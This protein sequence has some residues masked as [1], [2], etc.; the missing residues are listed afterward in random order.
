MCIVVLDS[1]MWWGW[2]SWGTVSLEGEH[3]GRYLYIPHRKLLCRTSNFCSTTAK[4]LEIFSQLC[5]SKEKVG[6][7]SFPLTSL[8]KPYISQ[9]ILLS[10][11]VWVESG[12]IKEAAREILYIIDNQK[13]S[14]VHK[15][16][17]LTLVNHPL[18]SFTSNIEAAEYKCYNKLWSVCVWDK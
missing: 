15:F 1:L 17:V 4:N 8:L 11:N 3:S 10:H 12:W 14:K 9:V 18:W 13:P 2:L 16:D 5:C 7:I 6:D